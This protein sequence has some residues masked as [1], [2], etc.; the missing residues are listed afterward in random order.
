[1]DDKTTYT[2]DE[3]KE[4]KKIKDARN[5]KLLEKGLK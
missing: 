4:F 2:K 3:L 5:E 1:M